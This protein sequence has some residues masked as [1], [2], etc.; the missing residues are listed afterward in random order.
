MD[1]L[2]KCPSSFLC[3][4]THAIMKDPVICS[5]GQSY[6]KEA[7]KTWLRNHDT[8]PLTNVRLANKD[9][10]IPNLALRNSIQEWKDITM[11]TTPT[12]LIVSIL[13]CVQ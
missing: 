5:D 11:K 6:E 9:L 3:P 1:H 10:I 2:H 4:I 7:I 12:S 13:G 8:S